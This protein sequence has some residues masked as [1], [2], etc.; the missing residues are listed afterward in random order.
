MDEAE[1]CQHVAFLSRGKLIALDTPEA[2]KQS[3][4]RGQ[5]LEI[6][7]SDSDRAVRVLR[8]AAEADRLPLSDIALYGAQIHVVVPDATALA[9]PVRALLVEHGIEPTSV[10]WIAPTL[11]DVFISSVR[12]RGE[13]D[14][15]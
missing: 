15:T 4:M 6:A 12:A 14:E 9:G 10:E 3:Q 2:L 7:C 13:A 8:Q 11:E 1:L 5:V